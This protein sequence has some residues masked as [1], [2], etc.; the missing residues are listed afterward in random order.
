VR[1][2]SGANRIALSYQPEIFTRPGV[3]SAVVTGWTADTL[4]GPMFRLVNTVVVADTGNP[5]RT[6]LGSI[7]A[8]GESRV[9]FAASAARPFSVT[10]A[11]EQ[12]GEQVLAYLHEP[13]GQPFREENGIGAGF[14]EQA[15]VLQVDARDVEPGLYEAVAAAP[16]LDGGSAT[17]TVDYSPVT[18]R[19][20]LDGDSVAIKLDNVS[21]QPVLAQPFAVL[22]GG[23]QT[24]AIRARGSATQHLRFRLPDWAVHATVDVHMDRAQWPL[25]TDFGVTLFGGDG[26]QLGKAP[27]NYAFGR[28]HVDLSKHGTG[29]AEV[30]LFPGFADAAGEPS[31]SAT[32]SIRLYA[33]SA[34]VTALPGGQRV[35][36]EPGGATT[37]H[38]PMISSPLPLGEGFLPLAIVVVPERDRTWTLEVP[39]GSTARSA[40]P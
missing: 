11:T 39:L 8:G 30:A 10:Y 16:P 27:L 18:I 29:P 21:S 17:I 1:L 7:A 36:V 9:F 25:F 4:A 12:A 13:G 33:D 20:G 26:R 15:G 5:I 40:T 32:V 23:E 31:W 14:G 35:N 3:Y 37:V 34:H 19:A 24:V 38:L 2:H 6:R 28:L 22:V